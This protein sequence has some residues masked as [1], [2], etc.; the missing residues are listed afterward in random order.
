MPCTMA[1]SSLLCAAGALMVGLTR[2]H[3]QEQEEGDEHDQAAP[4]APDHP[5]KAITKT[6]AKSV[7][8]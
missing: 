3:S 6:E 2:E 7:F 4:T 1:N 5:A 8:D